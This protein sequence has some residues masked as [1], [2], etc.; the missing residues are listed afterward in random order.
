MNISNETGDITTD[1]ADTERL[2]EYYEQLHKHKFDNSDN[3]D[4][5]DL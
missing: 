1:N 5:L 2:S 3:I 4:P